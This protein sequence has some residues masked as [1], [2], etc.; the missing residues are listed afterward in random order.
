[1]WFIRLFLNGIEA[2]TSGIYRKH[3][4][5]QQYG[6]KY[7]S[8]GGAYTTHTRIGFQVGYLGYIDE[9]RIR[10]RAVY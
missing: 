1:M 5:L 8:I 3:L 2:T 7:T 4:F 9:V 10:Q 6:L